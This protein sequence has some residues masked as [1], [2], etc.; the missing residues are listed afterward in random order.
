MLA[1]GDVSVVSGSIAHDIA[2][3]AALRWTSTSRLTLDSSFSLTINRPIVVAGPGSLTIGTSEVRTADYRFFNTGHIEFS[4]LSSGLTINGETY[5]LEKNLKTLARDIRQAPRGNFALTRSINA[6]PRVYSESPFPFLLGKFE[7]LGNTIANLTVDGGASPKVGL[8]AQISGQAVVRDL[9]L[10]NV[11]ITGSGE[12]GIGALVGYLTSASVKYAYAT[13]QVS[14]T[15]TAPIGGLIGQVSF[16]VISGSYADVSVDGGDNSTAVGGLTGSFDGATNLFIDNSYAIG[17]VSGGAGAS[18]G[19]LVGINTGVISNAY[20]TG[21]VTGGDG[22]K[23]GG[24]IGQNTDGEL[25]KPFL[26]ADYSIG[27]VSGGSGATVGGLI[28]EEVADARATSTYWDLDTSGISDPHKGAGNVADEDGITG[29][30]TAQFKAALPSGLT[31]L[32]WTQKAARNSG[33]P[34]LIAN[35][36][37]K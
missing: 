5:V 26:S 36:P 27:V 16:G 29:L 18:V 30:T 31:S 37:P 17:A 21:A 22:A 14:G 23:V 4:D 3:N 33:Y 9:G 20:A 12:K 19:G 34:Y 2:V 10:K 8:F 32:N 1:A 28:G 15:G 6:G 24:L 11:N 25:S 7:G 13:G 35:P